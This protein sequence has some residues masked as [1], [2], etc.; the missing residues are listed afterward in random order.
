MHL[1]KIKN[2]L[3]IYKFIIA[4]YLITKKFLNSDGLKNIN[5]KNYNL[6]HK[7]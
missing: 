5:L 2:H 1:K 3:I 4:F 6:H 7:F